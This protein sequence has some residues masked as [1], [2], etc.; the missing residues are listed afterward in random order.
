[1]APQTFS[2][3]AGVAV[4]EDTAIIHCTVSGV[5]FPNTFSWT[6]AE[7]GDISADSVYTRP[8]GM[9]PGVQLGGP[10]TRSDLTVKRQ[11]TTAL[12]PFLKQLEDAAGGAR[13]SVSWTMTDADGNANGETHTLTGVLKEVQWPQFD[14]NSTAA[15]FLT[16]VMACDQEAA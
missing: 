11:Y 9:Q 13:M 7:G 3:T 4:R 16:L 10:K 14:A 5:S 1:M 12:D 2:G 15:G 6:S 8:G